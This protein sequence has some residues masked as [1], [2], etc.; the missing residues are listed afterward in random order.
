MN[1]YALNLGGSIALLI[2]FALIAT[3]I[4]IFSYRRTVPPI[5]RRQK[6]GLIVLRSLG[7]VLLLFMLFK[8]IL[9]GISGE[10]IPPK[11]AVALDDSK[12]MKLKDAAGDR[13]AK[14]LKAIE[15]SGFSELDKEKLKILRFSED[16][17]NISEFALDSLKMNGEATNI[18]KPIEYITETARDENVQATLLITDGEFNQGANPIYQ[19]EQLGKPIFTIGVGDSVPPKDLSIQSIIANE[20]MFINSPAPVNVNVKISG[21]DTATVKLTLTDNQRQIGEQYFNITPQKQAFTAVFNY[22]PKTAGVHKIAAKAERLDDELTYKNNY[23]V[24]Y[25]KVLENKRNFAIFA[26]APSPDL[27]F[28]RNSL[29]DLGEAVEIQTYTQKPKGEFYEGTPTPE[30]L[31]DA[32]I[33]VFVGFPISSTPRATLKLIKK[34]LAKG[35][36]LFFVASK[37]TNYNLLRLLDEYLPFTPTSSKPMEFLALPVFEADA[38]TNPILRINGSKDDLKRWNALPP[39]FRTET[40]VK[41]KSSSQTIAT[42][43]VNNSPMDEPLIISGTYRGQKSV[44]VLGYGIYRWKLLGYASEVAKGNENALNLFDI[45]IKNSMKWLSVDLKD[46]LVE[47]KTNKSRYLAG[48]KVSFLAQVYD[49]SYRPIE[50][51]AVN[52]VIKGAE[53]VTKELTLNDLGNGR[54]SGEIN[55]LTKGG[56]YFSGEAIFEGKKIGSD[57]GRFSVGELSL[58]YQNIRMRAD[59]LRNISNRTGGKFYASEN[60]GEFINDLEKLDNFQPKT[61]TIRT[62][63]N[64]WNSPWLLAL[65]LAC[66]VVEWIIRKKSGML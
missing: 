48:E 51:A 9:T 59:L 65:A 55:N 6:T 39:I 7:I 35:K 21:Y 1:S 8:P 46:K 5:S 41:K 49:P 43:E 14:Y 23:V 27:S 40:F 3:A 52:V 50:N 64:L 20:T 44:A 25:V 19:A 63:I 31:K 42:F 57:A 29:E 28:I 53:G 30:K 4:A 18:T 10:E 32:E 37:F 13:E 47:I 22:T 15:S 60:A 36:S 61:V 54:Y 12:S 24:E 17:Y 26:G 38:T 34:E 45:F 16:Y 11:L 58:E 2:L 33:F 62:D 56:Y 66:F